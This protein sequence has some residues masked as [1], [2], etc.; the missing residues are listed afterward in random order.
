L[1][2][3]NEESVFEDIPELKLRD[4][5]VGLAE[6]IIDRMS[7]EFERENE[8]RYEN[9]MIELIRSKQAGL[10]APTEKAP[11]LPANVVNLMDALR[12][13]IEGS[14]GKAKPVAKSAGK[15]AAAEATPAKKRTQKAG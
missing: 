7:R 1:I 15:R 3:S 13:S 4:Q 12:R 6:E 14:G 5:M 11:P 9:A 2:R 8:D 10:P